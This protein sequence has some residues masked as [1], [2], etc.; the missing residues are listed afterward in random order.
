MSVPVGSLL[1]RIRGIQRALLVALVLVPVLI[2]TL[3]LVPALIVLP[4]LPSRTDHVRTLVA[5]LA[6][7][8]RTV[9]LT[10][11]ER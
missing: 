11:R 3:A 1:A 10:S 8:S 7:W 6:A 2:V 5:Q 9:L 4:F